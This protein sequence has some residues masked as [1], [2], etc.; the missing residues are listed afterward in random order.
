MFWFWVVI[1]I[2]IEFWFRAVY[3]VFNCDESSGRRLT[4]AAG[5]L[6]ALTDFQDVGFYMHRGCYVHMLVSA[7]I[8]LGVL[9]NLRSR[10]LK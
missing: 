5:W 10:L 6:W 7:V 4:F 1:D 2:M 8:D 9:S 3:V